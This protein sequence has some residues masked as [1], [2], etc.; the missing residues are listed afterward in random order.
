MSLTFSFGPDEDGILPATKTGRQ[1]RILSI[2]LLSCHNIQVTG[3]TA[4]NKTEKITNF[5]FTYN[6]QEVPF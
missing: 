2:H 4:V 6:R 3:H 5:V 1:R